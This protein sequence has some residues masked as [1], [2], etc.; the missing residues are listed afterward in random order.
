M[1]VTDGVASAFKL[2]VGDLWRADGTTR[3]VVGIVENPQSLLDEFALV[4]PG[5]VR[6]PNQVTV[7]FDAPGVAPKSIGPN[8]QTPATAAASNPLNPETIV[9]ALV[10]VT[11][12]LIA[13]MAVAGFTVLAQRRLRSLG[14]LASMGATDK[15]I[16]L[17]VRANGVVVGVAG[18]L[19]GAA[20]GLAA[21]LAYRPSVETNAHHVI[22]AFQL[23]WLVIAAAMV[24]AVLATFLAASRPARPTHQAPHRDGPVRTARAAQAGTPLRRPGRR[25]PRHR[26]A[27]VVV[28]RQQQRQRQWRSARA[29]LRLRR[30]DRGGDPAGAAVPDHAGPPRPGT[31]RSR[32]GWPCATWPATGPARAR[33]SRP[34]ASAC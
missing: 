6:A 7:L 23:P 1:A 19:I 24:L 14:M 27:P 13:L 15:H 5:Q 16:R 33:R 26:R 10:T 20:L 11:M 31:P 12:I 2:K 32:S 29:G 34:S 4:T 9:L 25:S 18:A 17:V 21:W 30:P 8:V 3:R 28:H 22:G